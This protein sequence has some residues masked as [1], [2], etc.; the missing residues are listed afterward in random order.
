MYKILIQESESLMPD[1]PDI[2]FLNV[3]AMPRSEAEALA[4]ILNKFVDVKRH[5][6]WH[7]AVHVDYE[8][9]TYGCDF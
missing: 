1:Y 6:R 7:K 3:P 5:N 2:D 9:Q 8:L 4:T